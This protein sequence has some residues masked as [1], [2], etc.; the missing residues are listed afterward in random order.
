[1]CTVTFLVDDIDDT[2]ISRV[3]HLQ[4]FRAETG[5]SKRSSQNG[6]LFTWSQNFYA[7]VHLTSLGSNFFQT[8]QLSSN[9]FQVQNV[10]HI[11]F[12]SIVIRHDISD[13]P[14]L[15]STRFPLFFFHLFLLSHWRS[16][17]PTSSI[18]CC[19]SI[20]ILKKSVICIFNDFLIRREEDEISYVRDHIQI[21]TAMD[22]FLG[23]F[24]NDVY[25]YVSMISIHFIPVLWLQW[26][27]S[28]S[29]WKWRRHFRILFT[30]RTWHL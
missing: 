20:W 30:S 18:S 25:G 27:S 22:L 29:S 11:F 14:L 2:N 19:I 8:C 3:L 6:T 10:C 28:S 4:R 7:F 9:R 5:T 23:Y 13:I 16:S 1:M 15:D 26:V 21:V 24:R 17:F 12:I